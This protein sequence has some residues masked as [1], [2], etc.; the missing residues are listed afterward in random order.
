M[1]ASQRVCLLDDDVSVRTAVARLVVA[2]GE[3]SEKRNGTD[4]A[5]AQW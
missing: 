1:T 2:A 5:V 4:Q 3:L